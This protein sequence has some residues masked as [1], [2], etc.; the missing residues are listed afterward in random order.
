MSEI[1]PFARHLGVT[2]IAAA[3]GRSEVELELAAATRNQKGD[4]HGGVIA[5]LMDIAMTR[6]VR[7]ADP[8]AWGLSTISMTVNYLAPGR[9][10]LA[11]RGRLVRAGT[12]IAVGEAEVEGADGAQVARAS[13]IFRIIRNAPAP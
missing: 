3:D 5:A 7:S 1:T 13:G 8:G 11:A 4:A 6:A 12:T 9:G 2:R 10:A